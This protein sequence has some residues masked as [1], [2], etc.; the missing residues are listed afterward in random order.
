VFRRDNRERSSVVVIED[1]PTSRAE[2]VTALRDMQ[3]ITLTPAIR[4]ERG[5]R[6]EQGVLVYDVGAA[7]S[8]TGLRPGD[9]IF[10]INRL[11]ITD[12]DQVTDVFRRVTGTRTPVRLYV[13][14]GGALYTTEFYVR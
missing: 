1:L 4:Q 7:A 11:R 9:V 6:S 10:Q 8:G 5:I 13:E 14:R 12:T 3:L 2:R